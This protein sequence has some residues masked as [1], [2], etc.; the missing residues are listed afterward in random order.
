[1]R[2][3]SAVAIS[4]TLMMIGL[5][6]GA[7][8]A[9]AHV[10]G[11]PPGTSDEVERNWPDACRDFIIDPGRGE[12]IDRGLLLANQGLL[13]FPQARF[14]PNF[15][16][17]SSETQ[18]TITDPDVRWSSCR[19]RPGQHASC[20]PHR[21]EANHYADLTTLGPAQLGPP[22]VPCQRPGRAPAG[23]GDTERL[24]VRWH[25]DLTGPAATGTTS[26]PG[27]TRRRASPA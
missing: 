17:Y 2:K 26:R 11:C 24:R 8:P 14:T 4:S 1:M 7:A 18:I 25:V 10:N 22:G 16:W 15:L 5:A 3:A 27:P 23:L 19:D 12:L 20:L 6:A 9:T 13:T 21:I